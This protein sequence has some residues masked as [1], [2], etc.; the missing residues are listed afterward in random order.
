[1]D[2]KIDHKYPK[3]LK[4]H[5]L[6]MKHDTIHIPRITIIG[7]LKLIEIEDIEVSNISWTTDGT[8]DTTNSPADVP[9]M[10]PESS[11]Q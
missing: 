6:S 7:N 10:P 5:L 8:A 4:I 1:M 3:L 9:R 11:F 2:H